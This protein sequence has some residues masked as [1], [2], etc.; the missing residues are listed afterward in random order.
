MYIYINSHSMSQVINMTPKSEVFSCVC[1]WQNATIINDNQHFW[2][3]FA[4]ENGVSNNVGDL[5]SG[6]D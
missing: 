3:G 4:E 5:P 2:K 6:Y 1:V